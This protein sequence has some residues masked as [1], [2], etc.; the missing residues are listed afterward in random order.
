MIFGLSDYNEELK[1][2]ADNVMLVL[3]QAGLRH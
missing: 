1:Y 2:F 3:K